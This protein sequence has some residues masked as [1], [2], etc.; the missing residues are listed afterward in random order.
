[1][2]DQAERLAPGDRVRAGDLLQLSYVAA[3]RRFGAIV[4]IDGRGV[5]TTHLP[6]AGPGA[7]ALGAGPAIPLEQ[8]YELDDAP[9]FERFVFVT[10]TSRFEVAVVAAAARAVATGRAPATTPLSLPTGLEQHDFVLPKE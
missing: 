4:S 10:G 6:L 8:A 3:G 9:G 5:V 7:A 1:R 2:G